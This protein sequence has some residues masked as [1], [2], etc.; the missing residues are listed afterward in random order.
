MAAWL[1]HSQL[2]TTHGYVQ[3]DLR[4]KQDA[5]D[6]ASTPKLREGTYPAPGV[7]VASPAV[8][9]AQEEPRSESWKRK[10]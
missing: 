3:V 8:K 7:T 1:G 6:A 4:M 10:R 5:L 9:P 2:S